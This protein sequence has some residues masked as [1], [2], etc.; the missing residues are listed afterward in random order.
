[1]KKL[2]LA[3]LVATLFLSS[4]PS[5]AWNRGG[6]GYHGGYNNNYRGGYNNNYRGGYN[7]NWIAPAIGGLIIGGMVGAAMAAPYY[8]P[9]PVYSQPAP[10]YIQPDPVYMQPS[11]MY[12]PPPN[13]PLGYRH[14]QILDANCNCYITVLVPN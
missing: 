5:Y 10:V 14:E 7:N 9:A 11:P 8:A 2:I 1:M 3:L 13:A 12:T 6:N 4:A